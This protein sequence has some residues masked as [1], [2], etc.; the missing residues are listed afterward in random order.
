V[1]ARCKPCPIPAEVQAMAF[2]KSTCADGGIA[3]PYVTRWDAVQIQHGNLAAHEWIALAGHVATQLARD[4]PAVFDPR[5][6][7]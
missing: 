5:K 3:R 4:F 1:I 6:P 7:R 2:V